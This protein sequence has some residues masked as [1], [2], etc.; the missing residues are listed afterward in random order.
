[1]IDIPDGAG[2]MHGA[3]TY[4]YAR[5]TVGEYQLRIAV[6]AG[7]LIGFGRGV[8][9][10][11]RRVHDLRTRC[12]GALL[13]TNGV[14]VAPTA[15]ALHGCTAAFGFP[16]HV[17]VP[18]SRRLRSRGGLVVHQGDELPDTDVTMIDGLRVLAADLAIADLLCTAPRRTAL[19]C[20]DQILRPLRPED[21]AGFVQDVA[22]RLAVRT[23][24]RGTRRAAEILALATGLPESSMQSALLLVLADAGL[25]QPECQYAIHGR[26]G[27]VWH[28]LDFAWPHAR[29]ALE[30]D[31]GIE[32][33]TR[34]EELQTRGWHVIRA[35]A[36]DLAD[37]TELC[38]ALRTALISS[39]AA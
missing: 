20:A 4:Q 37:P 24:R 11:T 35:D 17:R 9:L 38:R 12:A 8:L 26:S 28:R 6:E 34:E 27:L 14:L 33:D 29:V 13:L 16:V 18:Y 31:E 1:V 25:P 32:T 15:A 30:C 21:R 10:D 36:Q 23:D 2:G 3:Y 22:Q 5:A 39:K 7:E 19:A